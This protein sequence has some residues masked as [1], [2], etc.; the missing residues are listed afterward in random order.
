MIIIFVLLILFAI[1]LLFQKE[2]YFIDYDSF[3][4][5]NNSKSV[6]LIGDSMLNNSAYVS[7]GESVPDLLS[8]K[9]VGNATVYNFAKDGATIA[10]C[11]S[12][13]N[14]LSFDSN[15]TI[16][17]SCGGNNILNNR[18]QSLELTNLFAEYTQLLKSI[19]T[20]LPNANLYVLNL[21]M[22]ANGHYTSYKPMI[23]QWNKFLDDNISSIGYKV[24]K[25][26]DLL[27]AEED[28]IYGIEPSF[29][30]G[31]KLAS[32]MFDYTL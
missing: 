4:N 28:F 21:Y 1:V 31:K 17:V 15:T 5:K 24:L 13:L 10:D 2:T 29:K 14:K 6:V 7:Q 22:P 12:Q 20:R 26:S 25:T 11:Y 18:D 9:L 23:D 8:K 27:V 32:K 19:K 16:F 30:G 3:T